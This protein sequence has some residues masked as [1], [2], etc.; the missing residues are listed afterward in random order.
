MAS[1]A[2]F[3]FA[4]HLRPAKS[5]RRGFTLIELLVVTGII[6]LLISILLPV[7][8]AIRR[9]ANSTVCCSNLHQVAMALDLYASANHGRYPP[10]RASPGPGIYWYDPDRAGGYLGGSW[11]A[12]IGFEGRVMTCPEDLT[13]LRSY[14]MNF[15]ASGD[16]DPAMRKRVPEGAMWK[17]GMRDAPRLI[18]VAETFSS[19]GSAQDGWRSPPVIGLAGATPGQKFG[20]GGGIVPLLSIGPLGTASSEL[21]YQYHRHGGGARGTQPKGEAHMAYADLHVEIKT[22]SD[23]ADFN[24]GKSRL[25]TLWTPIDDVL[26]GQ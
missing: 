21:N 10:N 19:L 5:G 6:A 22:E 16:L 13:G 23:L 1:W 11:A 7:L 12:G 24:T 3:T 4:P 14:A 2:S 26:D 8:V 17:A 20:A 18:L 9:Q 25:T 15:F